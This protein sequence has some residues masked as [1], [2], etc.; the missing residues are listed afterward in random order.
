MIGDI[1]TGSCACGLISYE[2]IL[3]FKKVIICHCHNCQKRT[4]SASGLMIYFKE[5]QVRSTD[6][7]LCLYEYEA[8]SGNAMQ[9]HFCQICGTSVFLTGALNQGLIGV[10]GSC[11]D[12]GTFF[13]DVDRELFCRSK[14][15]FVKVDAK[16]SMETSPRYRKTKKS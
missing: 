7:Y 6:E 14:A 15:P 4:G 12:D 5:E 10:A 16:A 9:S 8:E 3:P 1:K 2:V 13:Y 11:F